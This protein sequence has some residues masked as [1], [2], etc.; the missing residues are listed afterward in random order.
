[1]NGPIGRVAGYRRRVL[2]DELDVLMGDLAAIAIDGAKG[3]GKTTT[4][5]ERASTA[6]HLDA[7]GTLTIAR[8]EPSRLVTGTPPILIDEWQRL[9][10]SWDLVR[11]AVDAGAAPGTFL[12]TG[13]ATPRDTGT[14][15][16]AGRIVRM[17]M[18]PLA[19]SERGLES[20]TVSLRELL[21]GTRPA[22]GGTTEVALRDY[23]KEICESGL[24]GIRGLPPRARRAQL[25]GYLARI[26]D[27]DF[28][29]AGRTVRNPAALRRWMEAYAAATSTTCSY[30]RIR[31]AATPGEVDKPAKTTTA[32]YRDVLERLWVIDDV[33][34]WAP[35]RNPLA[36]LVGGS[37]HHL[38][39]PAL[40][41]RLLGM[42]VDALLDPQ[43]DGTTRGDNL[44]DGPMLGRLFES[45]TALS[46][47]VYAQHSEASVSH[48]RTRAGEHEVDF[49]VER[50]D[51]RIVAVEAKLAH[52]VG[53]RDVRHLVWL[54]EKIGDG[55]LDA[56]VISTGSEAYRRPD[57]IGVVPA[58]LIGP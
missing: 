44:R 16:G 23:A 32:A 58:A 17:R 20:P 39:D 6:Y 3:V 14:H 36:R 21:T 55:L 50:P 30:D 54:R 42:D 22:L 26:I 49:V 27:R 51:H 28:P 12:L 19:L 56:I 57:G 2:D 31:D 38:A 48:L 18:R 29:D 9:P 24:P 7:P 5:A 8:A 40:V 13:S 11:R 34:A 53:D 41:V 52:E 43:G 45:L 15:S 33:P 35:S 46:L 47:R 25:D 4:A 37:T 10:G 1:M